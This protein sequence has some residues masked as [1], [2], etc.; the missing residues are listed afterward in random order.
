MNVVNW[1]A[2]CWNFI[3]ADRVA[4][5]PAHM[6]AA[7][8]RCCGTSSLKEKSNRAYSE[9][10]AAANIKATVNQQHFPVFN[11]QFDL[12]QKRE[13][14]VVTW[15]KQIEFVIRFLNFQ[16]V[17]FQSNIDLKLCTLPAANHWNVKSS[18]E[19]EMQQTVET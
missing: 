18:M 5:T 3:Y 7:R 12:V 17:S 15:L 6:L 16:L 10:Q 8:I 9:S 19:I 2:G 4:T 11:F 1:T 14:K 13:R